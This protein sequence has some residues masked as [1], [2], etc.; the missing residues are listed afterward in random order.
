MKCFKLKFNKRNTMMHQLSNNDKDN[1]NN[2]NININDN[3][4]IV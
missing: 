2:N 4:Q 3:K 1:N